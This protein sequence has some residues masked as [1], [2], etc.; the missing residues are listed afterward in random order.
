[1]GR[2][3]IIFQGMTDKVKLL[4]LVREQKVLKDRNMVL[5][6][7]SLDNRMIIVNMREYYKD[8][9]LMKPPKYLPEYKKQK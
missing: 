3:R 8:V 1:M 9:N 2:E 7:R 5:S 4:N 6:F